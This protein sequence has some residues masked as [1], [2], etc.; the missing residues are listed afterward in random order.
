MAVWDS[1]VEAN[2]APSMIW[3][4]ISFR[5]RWREAD[6]ARRD[7]TLAFRHACNRLHSVDDFQYT[8]TDSC[9]RVYILRFLIVKVVN[10]VDTVSLLTERHYVSQQISPLQS[11]EWRQP[12]LRK[13]HGQLQQISDE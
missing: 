10:D 5:H 1:G 6:T 11:R 3:A 7:A 4:D 13:K 2:T 12:R 8:I 9:E